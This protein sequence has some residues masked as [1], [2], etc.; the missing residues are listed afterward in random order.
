[1]ASNGDTVRAELSLPVGIG[2]DSRLA[3]WKER[4]IV[5]MGDLSLPP[6]RRDEEEPPLEFEINIRPR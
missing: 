3:I 6:S 4:I 5:E 1:M 2:E